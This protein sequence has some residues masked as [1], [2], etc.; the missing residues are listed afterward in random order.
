MEFQ[1][2]A[3]CTGGIPGGSG[4]DSYADNARKQLKEAP[5]GRSDTCRTRA[6]AGEYPDNRKGPW[7][8]PV[9]ARGAPAWKKEERFAVFSRDF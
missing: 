9:E 2:I 4:I 8:G 3:A 1:G 5:Q 7:R 6:S